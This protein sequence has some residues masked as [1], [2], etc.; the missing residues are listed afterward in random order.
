MKK[1][2][3]MLLALCLL[4]AFTACQSDGQAE[5]APTPTA[6]PVPTPASDETDV[7]SVAF[8]F[9]PYDYVGSFYALE[10]DAVGHFNYAL[11]DINGNLFALICSGEIDPENV[12]ANMIGAIGFLDETFEYVPFDAAQEEN[13]AH[14]VM[15]EI[16]PEYE[17]FLVPFLLNTDPTLDSDDL[18]AIMGSFEQIKELHSANLTESGGFHYGSLYL[19]YYPTS[20]ADEYIK[21]IISSSNGA[22]LPYDIAPVM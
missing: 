7:T 19:D 15:L 18:S 13:V 6:T 5:Q 16:L 8:A 17:A 14:S 4:L 9:S 10:T 21:L 12:Y 20:A 2:L 22:S 11:S 3:S 1:L